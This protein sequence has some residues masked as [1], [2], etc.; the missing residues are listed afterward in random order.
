[1]FRPMLALATGLFAAIASLPV[2]AA[3]CGPTVHQITIV[4]RGFL[5]EK[6]YICSGQ[7]VSFV[8]RT[9]TYA[10]FDYKTS[11]GTWVNT[12]WIRAGD[13]FVPG[14]YGAINYA[15]DL[16]NLYVNYRYPPSTRGGKVVI[17]TA[18]DKY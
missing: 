10:K 7:Q 9:G 12:G 5:P 15:T 14:P 6:Q 3:D 4:Y 13:T 18:P 1:M 2:Q 11:N 16:S 17:G 8:N